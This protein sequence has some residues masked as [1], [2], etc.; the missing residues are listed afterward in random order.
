MLVNTF[1]QL[2]NSHGRLV[3]V[4]AKNPNLFFTQFQTKSPSKIVWMKQGGKV[5]KPLKIP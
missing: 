2:T 1:L 4:S 5:E 3:S